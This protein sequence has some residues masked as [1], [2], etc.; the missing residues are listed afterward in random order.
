MAGSQRIRTLL[1]DD[2][3]LIR[4]GVASV[5][6]DEPDF[7]VVGEATNGQETIQ[8]ARE[9]MPDIILMDLR[10]PGVN[11]VETIRRI[12]QI[13]PYGKLV[14]LTES[15]DQADV[16]EAIKSGAEGYLAKKIEPHLLADT[17]RGVMRGER[18]LPNPEESHVPVQ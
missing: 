16:L 2:E 1:A 11:G 3:P 4:R 17:L 13:L 7:E 9:L 14:I 10:M 5:L 12:K 18:R 15:E 8:R 6:K